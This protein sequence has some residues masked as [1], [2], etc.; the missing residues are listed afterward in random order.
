MRVK[1]L[2]GRILGESKEIF[3]ITDVEIKTEQEIIVPVTVSYGT[4][5]VMYNGESF[6]LND[7]RVGTVLYKT[8]KK[9]SLKM[10]N[11]LKN[12]RVELNN[13]PIPLIAKNDLEELDELIAFVE[14]SLKISNVL[15]ELDS[16]DSEKIKTKAD[17]LEV[18]DKMKDAIGLLNE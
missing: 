18:L 14:E 11:C 9:D 2:K 16:I 17:I 13:S 7:S 15:K 5:F 4:E 12:K 3:F 10:L 1:V 6:D 8:A